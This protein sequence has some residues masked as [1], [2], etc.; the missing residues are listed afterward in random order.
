[1]DPSK[2]MG[3]A[4]GSSLFK[5]NALNN[6]GKAKQAAHQFNAAISNRNAQVGEIQ[7]EATRFSNSMAITK[8]VKESEQLLDWI[9]MANRS[10]GWLADT[11][12]PLKVAMAA[13]EQIDQDLQIMA[14]NSDVQVQSIREAATQDRL[15]AQ[16]STMYG[17]QAKSAGQNA[18]VGSLLS[19]A[20]NVAMIS[21]FA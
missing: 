7:A 17:Q 9:G 15:Q 8:F 13:A 10:N 1:M 3:M 11:G 4:V 19:T 18:A 12:T 16:L 5:A 20:A 6:E 21:A 14:F 2:A